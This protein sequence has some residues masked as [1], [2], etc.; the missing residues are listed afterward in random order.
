[1]RSSP[2]SSPSPW[3]SIIIFGDSLARERLDLFDTTLRDGAQT[4]GVDFTLHDK[5]VI[6]NM[7]DDLGIDYVEGG[8]PSANPTDTRCFPA[9]R[10]TP[11]HR[12]RRDKR[13]D[14]STSNDPA[15]PLLEPRPT[16]SASSPSPGTITCALRSSARRGKPRLDPRQRARA[17]RTK[18]ASLLDCEHFFDGYKANPEFALSCARRPT[19]RGALG[20]VCDTNGAFA[21][22]GEAIVGEV[23]KVIPGDHVG[24]HAHNDTEQAVANSFAAVRRR[25]PD[26]GHAQQARRALRQ[27][28]PHLHHPD[29]RSKPGLA[30]G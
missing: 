29:P 20:R 13:P 24:I 17:A 2:S 5:L 9:A 3:R 1:L 22:R 15:S 10:S 4:N 30:G 8:Y 26:P 6:A 12:L 25:A 14:G 18:A 7:L 21:A 28:Q 23:V 27:R 19:T 16:P 11:L